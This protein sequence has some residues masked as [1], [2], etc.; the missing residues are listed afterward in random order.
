MPFHLAGHT[1]WPVVVVA[2]GSLMVAH[3]HPTLLTV[4]R[5]VPPTMAFQAS[6]GLFLAFLSVYSFLT[7]DMVISKYH[8]SI[9]WPGHDCKYV[10]T[11]L[12]RSPTIC[13]FDPM[14][15]Q[16][17]LAGQPV[18]LLDFMEV[19]VGVGSE[20]ERYKLYD[21]QV[22]LGLQ[23]GIWCEPSQEGGLVGRAT[24]PGSHLS[25]VHL[26]QEA[27]I[28]E[29]PGANE[30][31]LGGASCIAVMRHARQRPGPGFR[32]G[33]VRFGVWGSK[34]T[35]LQRA[36]HCADSSFVSGI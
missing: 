1:A 11:H 33:W 25:T 13:W 15:P 23:G 24:K 14:G 6:G 18:H 34:Q 27:T 17:C 8:V 20:V 35:W 22:C 26:H 12:V 16:N 31:V 9:L 4:V 3:A 19:G 36:G 5:H 21:K 2:V 28:V 10:P 32:S 30:S 29:P 7:D